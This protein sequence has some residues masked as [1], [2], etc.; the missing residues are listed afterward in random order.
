MQAILALLS[1]SLVLVP[2]VQ[3][4]DAGIHGTSHVH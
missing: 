1:L 2:V 3:A 4:Q